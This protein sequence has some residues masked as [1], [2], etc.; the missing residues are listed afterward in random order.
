[1]VRIKVPEEAKKEMSLDNYNRSFQEKTNKKGKVVRFS[2]YRI[3][4]TTPRGLLVIDTEN[5]KYQEYL[6]EKYE[7]KKKRQQ[8]K[9]QKIKDRVQKKADKEKLKLTKKTERQAKKLAKEQAKKIK[10]T[11]R[12]RVKKEALEKEIKKLESA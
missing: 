5:T 7:N 2:R 1:M 4:G 10:Q 8:E 12:I 11:E 3:S 9:V 6:K